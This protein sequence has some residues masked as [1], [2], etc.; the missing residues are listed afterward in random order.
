MS[1][2]TALLFRYR[3]SLGIVGLCLVAAVVFN[4]MT[5]TSPLWLGFVAA[6]VIYVPGAIV[7][8][9]LGV[10]AEHKATKQELINRVLR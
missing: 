7:L 9:H 4:A 8:D 6:A 1:R 10:V 3:Y 5:S 2:T